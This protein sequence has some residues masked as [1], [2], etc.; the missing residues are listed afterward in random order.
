MVP[1]R[2]TSLQFSW[3]DCSVRHQAGLSCC[4][5]NC[6]LPKESIPSRSCYKE[7]C[8]ERS[9]PCGAPSP[10]TW[11]AVTPLQLQ[12]ALCHPRVPALKGGQYLRYQEAG[13][14]YLPLTHLISKGHKETSPLACYYHNSTQVKPRTCPFN[15]EEQS[16]TRVQHYLTTG[17][18]KTSEESNSNVRAFMAPERVVAWPGRNQESRGRGLLH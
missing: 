12:M 7:T 16:C 14:Q 4:P 15:R 5:H 1:L 8:P 10:C 9:L 3:S 17:P 2:L 11:P 13:T 18:R 6:S